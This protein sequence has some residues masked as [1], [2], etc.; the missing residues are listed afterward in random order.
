MEPEAPLRHL[1][2]LFADVEGSTRLAERHASAGS[3]LA[4]Y[5]AMVARVTEE[6]GGRVFERIGDGAYAAFDAAPPA[7]D[8]AVQLQAEVG[9]A[10]WGEV[11]RL[12]VRVAVVSGEVEE[13]DDRYFG[14]A[15]FVAARIQAL[16]HGGET[17]LSGRTVDELDGALPAGTRLRDLGTQRLRDVAQPEPI[18]SLVRAGRRRAGEA[19]PRPAAEPITDEEPPIRVLLVDDHAVVRRGLR[20]F[21]ELLKEIDIVGEA[22]NG[23]EAVAAA[24][25]L[26]PDV[27]LMDLQMPEMDGIQATSVIRREHP[28]TAVVAITSFIEEHKVAAALE[29]GA[30]GYL[31]KDAE[32]EEVANAIRRAARGE[33]HLDAAVGRLLTDRLRTRRA[34]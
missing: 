19:R 1:T 23:V 7:V 30:C 26:L 9:A 29:A 3:V 17:F 6:H 33:M 13:R 24:S 2:F 5:H 15:L 11:G 25:R 12:R 10:D 34:P 27:V 4:A 14:R 21:L 16:A 28:E 31:L 8:A 18:F 22:E 20:G 32:A